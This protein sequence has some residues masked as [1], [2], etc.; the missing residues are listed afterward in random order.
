V[1][2]SL[3]GED[4]YDRRDYRMGLAGLLAGIHSLRILAERGIAT[5]QD[6][7]SS[8]QGIDDVLKMIPPSQFP[9]EQRAAID[10]LLAKIQNTA[11][12]NPETKP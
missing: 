8:R 6:I 3:F 7:I 12:A 1:V 10:S 4:D 11:S 9:A 2:V 5:G